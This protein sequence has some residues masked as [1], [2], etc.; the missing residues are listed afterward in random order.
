MSGF[1]LIEL[2]TVMA[3]VAILAFVA[4]PRFADR[5]FEERGFRDAAKAAVQHARHVAVAS[6]RFV[7]VNV[8]PGTKPVGIVALKMD[9]ADPEGHGAAVSCTTDIAL[10]TP[11]R[12]CAA[13]NQVCA[14]TGVTLGGSNVI[15][16]ALG[17]SVTAPNVVAAT[18]LSITV[19]GQDPITV[20]PE[21]G[22]IQ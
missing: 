17:R 7:C 19:S 10:P 14:P 16:D 1:T 20:R 11:D 4:I 5:T 12:N 9:I 3:L 13:T 15:F 2:V 6:R 18:V 8:T 22:Y 21:T